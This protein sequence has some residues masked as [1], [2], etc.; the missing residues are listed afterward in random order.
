MQN[1]LKKF[2]IAVFISGGGSNLQALL[3]AEE[4][5]FFSSDIKLVISNK[6]GAFGLERA[7]K[8]NVPSYFCGEEKEILSL[9]EKYEIDLIVLAGYLKI[10]GDEILNLYSDRII[11]I[12]P[13][14]LPNYGGK[15]MYGI[16]VHRAVFESGDKRSGATVHFVNQIID[17]GEIILQEE[18]DISACKT[19]EEIASTVLEI[20][21]K[22]LPQAVK[23]LE[24]I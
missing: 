12:H 15:G 10:L 9:L 14:L 1:S 23:N 16:N 22:I 2:N 11:N 4:E 20:E 17:G 24:E 19:P 6:V 21:H 13:S 7:K 5:N 18:V 3:D 8:R